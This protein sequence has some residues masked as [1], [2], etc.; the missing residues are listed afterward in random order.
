M[1]QGKL[2][3]ETAKDCYEAMDEIMKAFPKSKTMEFIGNFN[4]IML[5]LGQAKS[6]LPSESDMGK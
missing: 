5:F 4:E 2:S 1:T 3:K 6:E